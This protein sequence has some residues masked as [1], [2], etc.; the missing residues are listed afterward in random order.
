MRF[1]E[2]NDLANR[3]KEWMTYQLEN[4]IT[5]P[6]PL[7]TVHMVLAYLDVNG[8]LRTSIAR[9]EKGEKMSDLISRQAAIDAFYEYPNITWT[10]LDIF[11][12]I[13]ELPSEEPE[14]EYCPYCKAKI[15]VE[16]DKE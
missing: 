2:R 9:L 13:S 3:C 7:D 6:F 4:N 10:T 8:Y 16:H 15:E 14:C 12:K 1:K 5:T 11:L